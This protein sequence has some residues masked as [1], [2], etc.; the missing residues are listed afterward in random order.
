MALT[1]RR[2]TR[3]SW[4]S[5]GTSRTHIGRQPAS[6]SGSPVL[7]A[8]AATG[9]SRRATCDQ[10]A[11]GET[12]AGC[13]AGPRAHCEAPG[14]RCPWTRWTGGPAPTAK[15]SAAP[16]VR[17][18]FRHDWGFAPR[19]YEAGERI[20]VKAPP[21][22]ACEG[23]FDQRRPAA[24]HRIQHDCCSAR[25]PSASETGTRRPSS[26]AETRRCRRSH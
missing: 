7:A 2:W 21:L 10:R 24:A 4:S 14:S 1:K 23:R 8:S 9:S 15:P 25:W 19:R 12:A 17:R 3:T 26:R 20:H 13:A 5:S 6:E 11:H 22:P 16:R 18:L